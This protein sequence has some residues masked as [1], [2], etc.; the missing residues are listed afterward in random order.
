[1]GTG[2]YPADSKG[3]GP[4]FTQRPATNLPADRAHQM[5]DHGGFDYGAGRIKSSDPP[6]QKGFLKGRYMI[7]HLCKEP[8]GL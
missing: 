1:M 6:Q 3:P 2:S 5:A 8:V 7:E 4:S